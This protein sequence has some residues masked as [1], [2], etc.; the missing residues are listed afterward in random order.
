[1]IKPKHLNG[2]NVL[3]NW[4]IKMPRSGSNGGESKQRM[5]TGST[6][7]HRAH[8]RALTMKVLAMTQRFFPIIL[9]LWAVRDAW[10]CGC[11]R[12]TMVLIH[13][14]TARQQRHHQHRRVTTLPFTRPTP[15]STTITTTT[16]TTQPN[17]L[18]CSLLVLGPCSCCCLPLCLQ[19]LSY[20]VLF[21]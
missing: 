3:Q 21:S 8:T 14:R 1:M 19:N 4:A 11:W 6:H 9:C 7:H 18:R 10:C 16:P 17:K 13:P 20:N 2:S 5:S 12:C 15:S